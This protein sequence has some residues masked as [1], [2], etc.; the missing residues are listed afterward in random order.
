MITTLRRA[1]LASLLAVAL[2]PLAEAGE[3]LP[4]GPPWFRQSEFSKAHAKALAE[5]KP[6]F[7]YFTKTY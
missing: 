3:K 2:A 1:L 5:S 4:P 6:L 7:V